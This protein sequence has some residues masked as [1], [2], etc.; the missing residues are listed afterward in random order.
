MNKPLQ[1][2]FGIRDEGDALHVL[3]RCEDDQNEQWTNKTAGEQML[4]SQMHFKG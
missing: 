2:S 4:Q 3:T 1:V